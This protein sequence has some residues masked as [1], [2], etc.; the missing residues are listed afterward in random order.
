MSFCELV[1]LST[2]PAI[3]AEG[4]SKRYR[5]NPRSSTLRDLLVNSISSPIHRMRKPVRGDE[6]APRDEGSEGDRWIWALR[7]VSFDVPSGEAL[8]VIGSNGAGKSTLLR[9]LCRIT[10]PTD[11][12][13]DL[14]GRVGSLLEVGTGFHPELSGRENIYLNGAML[15]MARREIGRRFDEIVAFAET[16]RFLDTPVKFYSSGMYVRLAFAVAAHLEPEI[17]LVDEVLAVGDIRFQRKCLGKMSDAA[18]EGR[19]VVF[20]SHNMPAV[21]RLC[22]RA[23]LIEEG[24]VAMDGSV[25]QVVQ[26][27]LGSSDMASAPGII[28]RDWPRPVGTDEAHLR[29]VFLEDEH[30]RSITTVFFGQ[31]FVVR[32]VYEVDSA[33]QDAAIE[34]GISTVDGLRI[35]TAS[36]IDGGHPVFTFERG[37]WEVSTKLDVTLLPGTYLID[38]FMHHVERSRQTIDWVEGTFVFNAADV[39]ETGDDHYAD[40]SFAA[41]R[42]F[43]RPTTS[44]TK[45]KPFSGAATD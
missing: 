39:A 44:W 38:V 20:V 4:L 13:A 35:A 37:T 30:G 19:T 22:S 40:F 45:P 3:R 36:N 21:K 10:R 29:Q 41:V 5:I 32:A 12:Y 8:A 24:R 34:V 33:I 43:I 7:D 28:P 23:V 16:E 31:R 17:L 6:V 15:G 1:E 25:D 42:G 11:G 27:Y 2:L 26:A 18:G 14:T 9:I